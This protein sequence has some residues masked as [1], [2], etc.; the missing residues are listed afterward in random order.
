MLNRIKFKLQKKKNV[1]SISF[2]EQRNEESKT[3]SSAK[4]YYFYI[5]GPHAVP[6]QI[7]YHG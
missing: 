2:E 4:T 1:D 7:A 3:K 5:Y 6:H